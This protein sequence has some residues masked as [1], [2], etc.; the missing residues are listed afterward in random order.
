MVVV[1]V[2]AQHSKIN[3]SSAIVTHFPNPGPPCPDRPNPHQPHA[4]HEKTRRSGF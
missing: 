4:G 3:C 2:V 1:V